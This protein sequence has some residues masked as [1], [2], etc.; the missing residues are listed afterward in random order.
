MN[1]F[2]I[3]MRGIA[4]SKMTTFMEQERKPNPLE[5]E[6]ILQDTNCHFK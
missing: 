6:F 2:V 4:Y 3:I 5:M 1:H